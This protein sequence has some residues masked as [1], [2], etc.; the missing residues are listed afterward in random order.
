ME[1]TEGS[2]LLLLRQPAAQ[3]LVLCHLFVS[4]ERRGS[5]VHHWLLNPTQFLRKKF[6]GPRARE[7]TASRRRVGD[8][9]LLKTSEQNCNM[10]TMPFVSLERSSSILYYII[11]RNTRSLVRYKTSSHGDTPHHSSLSLL[12]SSSGSYA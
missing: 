4:V 2:C 7:C 6:S 12:L 9:S 10:L 3:V 5:R 8:I 1:G 11:Q